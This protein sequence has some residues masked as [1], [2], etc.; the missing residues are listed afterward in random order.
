MADPERGPWGRNSEA[1]DRARNQ[2]IGL[3]D[4]PFITLMLNG[5]REQLVSLALER[6]IT[7]TSEMK[8]GLPGILA[9]LQKDG[10]IFQLLD[11]AVEM[12]G[13][14]NELEPVKNRRIE[15]TAAYEP[16][17]KKVPVA[18]LIISGITSK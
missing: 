5:F 9:L 12:A 1:V 4:G 16:V 6:R 17:S 18:T 10:D 14:A 7:F 8:S 2:E 3:E 11:T 13:H 15:F